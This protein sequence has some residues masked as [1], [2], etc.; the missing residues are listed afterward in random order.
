[1]SRPHWV[2]PPIEESLPLFGAARSSD[3]ATSHAAAK[4]PRTG[5]KAR[6]LEALNLGPAG[7]TQL[8]ARCGML[9][10]EVNKRLN[11]LRIAGLA[12]RTGREVLNAGGLTESEWRC[13]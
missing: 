13:V 10:H 4:I 1:M 9:P 7:Q 8:A 12:E 11:D 2:T 5:Q 6:V 3:P